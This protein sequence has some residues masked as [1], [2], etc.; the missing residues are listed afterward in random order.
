MQIDID[1][2]HQH[3]Q[4]FVNSILSPL[5]NDIDWQDVEII[6]LRQSAIDKATEY[7][8]D[9][10]ETLSNID[11]KISKELTRPKYR[12]IREFVRITNDTITIAVMADTV[13][14]GV[15]DRA[16][17]MLMVLSDYAPGVYHSGPEH[18]I[19]FSCVW[20]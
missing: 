16:M 7:V 18:T 9:T 13:T 10:T 14:D 3:Q 17:D 20:Y 2:K 15:V 5:S 12:R 19:H 11:L 1:R 8:I 6:T 4:T